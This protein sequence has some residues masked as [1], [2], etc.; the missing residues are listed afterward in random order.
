MK[1]YRGMKSKDLILRTPEEEKE[2]LKKWR[3]VLTRRM[4]GNYT[5]PDD[6]NEDIVNLYKESRFSYQYFTDRRA[7]AEQYVN[8][9]R[10]SLVEIDVSLKDILKYFTLEFQNYSSRKKQFEI[11]YMVSSN[12]LAEKQERWKLKII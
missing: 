5:Y 7:I 1:L 11:V 2:Y 4:K 3:K 10:G 8:Q 6:L 12:I 9:Q